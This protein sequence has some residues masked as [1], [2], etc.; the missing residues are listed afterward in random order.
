M[1]SLTPIEL[2][3]PF[4]A[5]MRRLL[6]K[7]EYQQ[8]LESFSRPRT[9]GLRLNTSK[10]TPEEFEKI[11][12]FPV[13][14]IPFV[15]NAYYYKEESRPAKCPLYH[16][17]LYYLQDPAAMLPAALLPVSEQD[18]V[19]DLCAAPGGKATA[20]G[21]RLSGS[22]L[23]IANDKNTSRSK[24]LLRNMELFGITNS[25]VVNEDPKQLAGRFPSLFDAILL[26]AP[27]SGEGMFRKDASLLADWSEE[28]SRSLAIIQKGLMELAVSML[29]PGGYL[30]YSTCTYAPCENEEVVSGI[31]SAHPEMSLCEIEEKE[32][33]SKGHPVD[34]TACPP[35]TRCL[36]VYPHKMDAEG[37]FLALLRKENDPQAEM[38]VQRPKKSA[39]SSPKK[40]RTGDASRANR[41]VF[42]LLSVFLEEIGSCT[43]GGKP[44]D[45][46][47][48]EER[49]GKLYLIPGQEKKRSLPLSGLSFLR[50][51]LYL[52]DL[53][54]DRFE[55]SHPFALALHKG[56]AKKTISLPADDER[57]LRYLKGEPISI[58][59]TES[60]EKGWIVLCV[61]DYP[62][63]FGKLTGGVLKNKIPVGWRTG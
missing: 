21:A 11:V 10:I 61:E 1:E 57:L 45:P 35:L 3:G 16:A 51:G 59:S 20:V 17:G 63:A 2:P 55:P 27:C 62:L 12:P 25:F 9:F 46:D 30:M 41:D 7:E 36:R 34:V 56:D 32:G 22:G 37:Q 42:R 54:K 28:K 15:E 40:K 43:V 26:D 31:L 47:C 48:V 50:N 39:S 29:R 8:F 38:P 19:L 33:F 24:A 5:R 13:E 23:L 60:Q 14:R 18:L 58:R 49:G 53:R 4:A 6:E 44:L 52:G